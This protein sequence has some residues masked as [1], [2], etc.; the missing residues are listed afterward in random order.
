MVRGPG[1]RPG[2]LAV[3]ITGFRLATGTVEVEE[4]GKKTTLGWL[5]GMAVEQP[6]M[7]PYPEPV[8]SFLRCRFVFTIRCQVSK[9]AIKSLFVEALA[10]PAAEITNVSSAPD[11]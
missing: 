10:L 2:A 7:P 1:G 5:L 3:R 6:T 8:D 11:I 9:E 4:I